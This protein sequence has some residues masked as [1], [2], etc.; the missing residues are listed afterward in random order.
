MHDCG[1]YPTTSSDDLLHLMPWPSQVF[2]SYDSTNKRQSCGA[3]VLH[4]MGA[5][6]PQVLAFA[7]QL[8]ASTSLG[9]IKIT[10]SNH[11]SC[12][13]PQLSMNESYELSV[14]EDAIYLTA[15]SRWGA[16]RAVATLAQLACSDQLYRG[17]RI[18][19]RP[20]F[21]WRGLLLDVARH[22]FP[23]ASLKLV[24]DG[25]AAVKMN[26][27]HLHLSD[28]QGF[29]FP[30]TAFPNLASDDHYT[31]DELR[32]L[33][34]YAAHRGVRIVPE[35]DMPGHVTSWLVAHPEWGTQQPAATRRFGVHLSLIHI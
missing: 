2:V 5:Q 22:F 8:L 27:L 24:I 17:L 4:M 34:S 3:T 26:V 10:V 19:D 6:S 1:M 30:S 18:E 28:D 7:E 31:A 14:A 21:A 20:R 33:V 23:I 13:A 16:L 11:C 15:H 29:R 25:L 32:E 35:L 12:G 9:R